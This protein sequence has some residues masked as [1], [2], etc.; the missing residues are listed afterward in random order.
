MYDTGDLGFWMESGELQI[1]GRADE[2]VKVKV[3]A[4]STRETLPMKKFFGIGL[5][6]RARWYLELYETSQ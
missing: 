3:S 1:L 2:Q 6:C 4:S 5:P